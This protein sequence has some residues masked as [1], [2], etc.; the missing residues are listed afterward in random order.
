GFIASAIAVVAVGIWYFT[1]RASGKISQ[2]REHAYI[3]LLVGVMASLFAGDVLGSIA[4]LLLGGR[5]VWAMAPS[6]ALSYVVLLWA[7]AWTSKA[8]DSRAGNAD[9]RSGTPR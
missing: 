1:Q 6:Y 2:K 4:S 5:S 8:L 7:I 9:D 3:A